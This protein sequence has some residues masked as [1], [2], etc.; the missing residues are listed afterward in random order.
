MR[1][2]TSMW[3]RFLSSL[4]L[5]VALG[6]GVAAEANESVARATVNAPAV[7]SEQPS[8]ALQKV[9][10]R[11]IA[12]LTSDTRLYPRLVKLCDTFGPRL[13]GSANLERALDWILAEL[14][15]DGVTSAR[16]EPVLVP[17]WVRH[18]EQLTLQVPS[19]ESLPVLAL[20]GSV[21]TPPEGVTAQILVVQRFDELSPG[22]ARDKIVLF[23]P[24]FTSYDAGVPLRLFGAVKAA[25][26]GAKAAL[27]R[28]LTPQSLGTPHTGVTVYQPG[29][30]KIPFAAMA[31]EDADRLV[32]LSRAGQPIW[33]KLV[34]QSEERPLAPSRNIV[35]EVV[36]RERPD[37][38]VVFGCHI[39][40]WDVG[41]GAHDDGGNCIAA[42]HAL[43]ALR[44]HKPRRTI[45][46][47]M[48][49]NEENGAAGAKAYAAA[50]GHE[51][52]VLGLEADSGVFRP[53]G[54]LFSGSS[55]ALHK[56]HQVAALLAPLRAT[57]VSMPGGGVDIRPLAEKGVPVVGLQV[58]GDRYFVYHHSAA[59]TVDKVDP[60]DLGQVAAAL[61]VFVYGAAEL[62]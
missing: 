18:K 39:D 25:E 41:Q 31:P 50:H 33:A 51:K 3:R 46:L 40:S 1:Q 44:E 47:V 37:E 19:I 45:R 53:T 30:S 32:R 59:D 22:S 16:G 5:G 28:S 54:W 35:A 58:A 12:T 17:H 11:L 6:R 57:M 36:G 7:V 52:H 21:S 13:S 48:W 10:A 34:L 62:F 14:Q 49:V 38:V 9:A 23:A 24:P 20:G 43:L 4:A 15:R 26:A 61:A 8:P 2:K 42:W 60:V 29:V 55:E 27:L 56:V